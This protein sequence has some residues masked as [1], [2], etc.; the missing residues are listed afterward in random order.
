MTRKAAE[1]PR[2]VR[3]TVPGADVSVIEWLDAQENVSQ[4]LR[5]LIRESIQR[6]GFIDV[7]YKPVE[8]LPRK[9][10]PAGSG[11]DQE[12]RGRLSADAGEPAEQSGS[13]QANSF[14]AEITTRE[15]AVHAAPEEVQPT[16][17]GAPERHLRHGAQSNQIDVAQEAQE[18]QDDEAK[19]YTETSA[20]V[21]QRPK[22]IPDGLS[23]FLT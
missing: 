10:R 11:L 2:K 16:L 4:S 5:L 12:D 17:A 21:A 13:S 18:A 23:S 7:V 22:G 20:S 9:G 15:P 3:W 14:E 1:P 8:Q 19:E 6:D